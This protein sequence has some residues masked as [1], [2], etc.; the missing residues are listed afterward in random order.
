ML[1]RFP[2]ISRGH[3]IITNT[4]TLTLTNPVTRTLSTRLD[5]TGTV[6]HTGSGNLNFG[7]SSAK[8]NHTHY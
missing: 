6:I 1:R 5:N 7:S 3:G 8:M 4:G 2:E